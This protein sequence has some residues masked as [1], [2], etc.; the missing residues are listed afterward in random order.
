MWHRFIVTLRFFTVFGFLALNNL[1]AQNRSTYS[2]NLKLLDYQ[3]MAEYAFVLQGN[4]TVLDGEFRFRES[5]K[6]NATASSEEDH[7]FRI[8]GKFNLD[9]PEGKW[10]YGR[11]RYIPGTEKKLIN[12]RYVTELDG[13]QRLITGS[14][15]QGRPVGDW[16]I[17]LDSIHNSDVLA[18]LFKSS[19]HY[20]AGMPAKSFTI[21]TD[22]MSMAGRLLRDGQAHD[23]W[24]LYSADDIGEQES[25]TFDNGL[26]R[27]IAV[28]HDEGGTQNI[29]YYTGDYDRT[30]TIDL[31]RHFLDILQLLQG[32]RDSTN[33]YSQGMAKLL[34]QNLSY[35]REVEQ[36][37]ARLGDSVA[38]GH[39][40]V[41][42]PYYP[43]SDSTQRLLAELDTIYKQAAKIDRALL[44]DTQLNI[45]KLSDDKTAELYKLAAS[46]QTDYLKPLGN[47]IR[48]HRE[49]LLQHVDRSQIMNSLWP[50]GLP[51]VNLKNTTENNVLSD[52]RRSYSPDPNLLNIRGMAEYA[53]FKLEMVREELNLKVDQIKKSDVILETEDNLIS[54]TRR[55]NATIDNVE[56]KDHQ[57]V[58][59]T[60]RFISSYAENELTSYSSL[61]DSA[62]KKIEAEKLTEC[63]AKLALLVD[64]VAQ[65]PLHREEIEEAYKDRVWNPFTATLMDEEI[66]KRITKAYDKKVIPYIHTELQHSLNCNNIATWTELL[67]ELH[68]RMLAMST[69]DT[70]RLERKVKRRDDAA[71]ILELFGVTATPWNIA[72]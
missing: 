49:D 66:K 33:L 47:L 52:E 21:A 65:L 24:T 54:V 15:E 62:D 1:H 16:E 36:I 41:R 60:L 4:D 23:V 43:L 64:A 37:M 34:K 71:E 29:E 26:L 3:G 72:R 39:I 55:L 22:E 35:Y 12:R 14:Y 20:E 70:K 31:D 2:G 57:E 50:D 42:V 8:E 27:T 28:K 10:I 32:L 9:R 13:T 61:A 46:V 40:K 6:T 25:W 68:S 11:S 48:Y 56:V 5:E 38:V 51:E 17:T 69:E 44:N 30:K 7:T 59:A 58:D 45:L 53:L 19:L 67:S 63:F 18:T